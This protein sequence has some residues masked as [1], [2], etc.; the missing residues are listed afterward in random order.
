M[1]WRRWRRCR[2]Q[3]RGAW[4]TQSRT[5]A[6]GTA[7]TNASNGSPPGTARR[8]ASPAASGASCGPWWTC[9]AI[10]ALIPNGCQGERQALGGSGLI[11]EERG[12]STAPTLPPVESEIANRSCLPT[13]SRVTTCGL[14]DG[15]RGNGPTRVVVVDADRERAVIAVPSAIDLVTNSMPVTWCAAPRS[16]VMKPSSPS[17]SVAHSVVV[18]PSIGQIG[19]E[20]GGELR[21]HGDDRCG[22]G[23]VRPH[24]RRSRPASRAARCGTNRPASGRACRRRSCPGHVDV[25]DAGLRSGRHDVV[26]DRCPVPFIE[27]LLL[28]ATEG[29]SSPQT[30]AQ[31]IGSVVVTWK[32]PRCGSVGS[33][34]K[35]SSL[36]CTSAKGRTSTGSSVAP[37]LAPWAPAHDATSGTR[38]IA[39]KSSHTA[40]RFGDGA[41]TTRRYR[42]PTTSTR[43]IDYLG[44]L[45]AGFRDARQ[46][47][48]S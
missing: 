38:T 29:S 35:A 26:L 34:S 16:M 18:S 30:R 12:Y 1:A 44:V 19:G 7:T 47:V 8:R 42:R 31:I 27:K 39:A 2:G 41:T 40:R 36:A 15:G 14:G 17:P 45:V 48:D 21:R 4:S 11:A 25:L 33:A 43:H 20:V 5:P 3:L 37:R 13:A 22:K 9:S 23:K 24:G 32:M 46:P 10:D 28:R 6:V